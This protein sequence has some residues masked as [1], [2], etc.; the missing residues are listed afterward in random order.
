MPATKSA[1]RSTTG[2]R[3]KARTK[4][5]SGPRSSG[6]SSRRG[7]KKAGPSAR[8]RAGRTTRG[9]RV[10]K[11]LSAI[12]G[13]ADA[14]MK[15]VRSERFTSGVAQLRDRVASIAHDG[16]KAL[17]AARA[18]VAT[19]TR[20]LLAWGK[21]HPVK[22]AAAAAAMLAASGLI[23]STMRPGGALAPTAGK[24]SARKTKPTGESV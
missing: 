21:K 11:T 19:A 23:Y 10:A 24:R 12:T 4:A 15:S 2:G 5:R 3:S 22:T 6:A 13:S 7:G 17:E 14:V 1:T 16:P 18:K 8:K 9:G 20:D